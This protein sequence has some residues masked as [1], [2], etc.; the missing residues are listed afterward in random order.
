MCVDRSVKRGFTLIE[1]LV[2]IAIIAILIAL[3]LPAV[4]QAREAARRSSCKNNIKQLA[5]G[6]HNYLDTHKVFPYSTAGSLHL[7]AGTGRLIA[8]GPI[9]TAN[10]NYVAS[11]QRG[12][13]MVL[14]YLDQQPLYKKCNFNGAF[15]HA[16]WNGASNQI[17]AVAPVGSDPNT[18]GNAEVASTKLPVFLCPSDSGDQSYRSNS[19]AYWISSAAFSAGRFGA[20]TSYDFSSNIYSSNAAIW[21]DLATN[22]RRMFGLH[23]A[24]RLEDVKDGTSQAIMLS[25]TTL[26]VT[27]GIGQTWGYAKWV[28][29][30]VDFGWTVWANP[31]GNTRGINF[32]P[33]CP[34]SGWVSTQQGRLA[35]W[36]AP[37]SQH[38]GGCHIALGDASVRFVNENIAGTIRV[39]LAT[40]ADRAPIGEF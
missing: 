37:G 32:W 9:K 15:G 33:C 31:F 39:G 20:K 21:L 19:S 5:T 13:P 16:D 30:G 17:A 29:N 36:G 14:P 38:S 34:W 28:G 24:S 4:Q 8:G 12:W 40:I 35:N 27:N 23:S 2:V 26:D 18:N 22:A 7:S 1:L 11:N 25:E 6:L 10:A 3:L